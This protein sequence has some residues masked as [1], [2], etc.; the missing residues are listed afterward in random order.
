MG[1]KGGKVMS[2]K[3]IPQ[4]LKKM[5]PAYLLWCYRELKKKH[6]DPSDEMLVLL[7]KAWIHGKGYPVSEAERLLI[8]GGVDESRV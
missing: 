5:D 8:K 6:M 4:I 2:Y 3:S 7:Y 1:F